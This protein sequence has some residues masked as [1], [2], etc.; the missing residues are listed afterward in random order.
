MAEFTL[1]DSPS[2]IGQLANELKQ[3]KDNHLECFK[4]SPN[5]V[6]VPKKKFRLLVEEQLAIRTQQQNPEYD[7][8]LLNNEIGK[9][10]NIRLEDLPIDDFRGEI[11]STIRESKYTIIAGGLGAGKST[12]VPQIIRQD[13][14]IQKKGSVCNIICTQPKRLGAVSVAKRV[15]D[16]LGEP[17]GKSV[18][19]AIH[20]DVVFP[21]CEGG[22]T[23]TYCTTGILVR[24][25]MDSPALLNVSHVILDE[26]HEYSLELDM[27]LT[28]LKE[29][30]EIRSDFKLIVMSATMD[31]ELYKKHLNN[32]K[33]VEIGPETRF[34]V[35]T[36]YINMVNMDRC[37]SIFNIVE[38]INQ[39]QGWRHSDL[40]DRMA[41][42]DEITGEL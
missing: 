11:A 40:C 21:A 10:Q 25:L 22:A 13:Q 5:T 23:I 7:L 27:L 8:Q 26:V 29:L 14:I 19:Y 20:G 12:R 34:S 15:A 33:V 41:R 32:C 2:L 4:A 1:T 36:H 3:L 30:A 6:E 18:G 37:Y 42:H 38:E 31:K 35:D 17:M 39:R 9:R 28:F 16:E 24:K